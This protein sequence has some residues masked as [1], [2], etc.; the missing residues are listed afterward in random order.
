MQFQVIMT[1]D[2]ARTH[3]FL[4]LNKP[5][6]GYFGVV[7]FFDADVFNSTQ[8]PISGKKASHTGDDVH[9][10]RPLGG[11]GKELSDGMR[12]NV[13]DGGKT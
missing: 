8:F 12:L 3:M 10:F 7:T 1:D 6:D 11:Q 9:A 5:N 4:V 2:Q 13:S